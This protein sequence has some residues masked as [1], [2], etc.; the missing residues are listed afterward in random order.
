M[1][2]TAAPKAMTAVP[3]HGAKSASD[4]SATTMRFAASQGV[5]SRVLWESDHRQGGWLRDPM[6]DDSNRPRS[7]QAS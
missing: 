1:A 2:T 3:E 7:M 4:E 5:S 6:M